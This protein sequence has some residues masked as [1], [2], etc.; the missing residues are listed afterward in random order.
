MVS[1]RVVIG[2]AA[3]AGLR[4][5]VPASRTAHCRVRVVQA[6]APRR[7]IHGMAVAESRVLGALGGEGAIGSATRAAPAR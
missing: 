4:L 5:D 6:F 1:A 3:F 7:G 2:V